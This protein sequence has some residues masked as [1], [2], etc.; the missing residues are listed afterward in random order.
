MSMNDPLGHYGAAARA[1]G[2]QRNVRDAERQGRWQQ[3]RLRRSMT[4]AR[5]AGMLADIATAA[6]PWPETRG[7]WR[8]FADLDDL[9]LNAQKAWLAALAEALGAIDSDGPLGSGVATLQAYAATRSRLPGLAGLLDEH[10]GHPVIANGVQWEYRMV[11]RA[12]GVSDPTII[13]V[14]ARAAA[15][16]LGQESAAAP[17]RVLDPSAIVPGA[18]DQRRPMLNRMVGALQRAGR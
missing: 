15:T 18:P 11:A 13:L 16:G 5:R 6:R 14:Q 10:E 9:L 4:P 8:A 7:L 1:A 3:P 2:I 12:A 17:Q